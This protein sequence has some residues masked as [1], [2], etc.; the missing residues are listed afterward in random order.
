MRPLCASTFS[1]TC[2]WVFYTLLVVATALCA[3]PFPARAQRALS[4]TPQ[5]PNILWL[6]AEDMGPDLG[7]S[8][9][10]EAHTPNSMS[11]A[12]LPRARRS[13][14]SSGW[15]GRPTY[16]SARLKRALF[17]CEPRRGRA[18]RQTGARRSKGGV[19]LTFYTYPESSPS[20]FILIS[21]PARRG[22]FVAAA[23][24]PLAVVMSPPD[25]DR[26]RSSA[27][28]GR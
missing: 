16:R 9:T 8:G 10:P 18:D 21:T 28:A 20:T 11:A 7:A 17:G 2:P 13:R 22:P 19:M 25:S 6:I 12:R 14:R 23:T 1:N 27:Q 4:D 3:A 5:R 15:L 24:R 26:C